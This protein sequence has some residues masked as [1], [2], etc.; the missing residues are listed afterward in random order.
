VLN[1]FSPAYTDLIAELAADATIHA[2]VAVV[3]WGSRPPRDSEGDAA[4]LAGYESTGFKT[5]GVVYQRQPDCSMRHWIR[6]VA[7]TGAAVVLGMHP[8]VLQGWERYVTSYGRETLLVHSLGN[9]VSHGGYE[10]TKPPPAF[11]GRGYDSEISLLLRRTSVL[12]QFGLQWNAARNWAEVS[13]LS[14]VPLYRRLTDIGFVEPTLAAENKTTYEIHVEAVSATEQP[15]EHAFVVDRFGPLRDYA[16]G[17]GVYSG[18]SWEAALDEDSGTYS[19][20][21]YPM[22]NAPVSTVDANLYSEVSH[23][24]NDGSVVPVPSSHCLKCEP[25]NNEEDD[26]S[27]CRWCEYQTYSYC[28][29][30]SNTKVYLGESIPWDECLS[31]AAANA[32]CSQYAYAGGDIGKCTCM[33]NGE[34][35]NLARSTQSQTVY[36]RVCGSSPE[37][38]QS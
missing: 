8:H 24:N 13:C 22:S 12:L 25:V 11:L 32:S 23:T 16:S 1:C 29:G 37:L 17:G 30:P 7:E 20:S 14:Y 19:H 15:V 26:G 27:G 33:R 2:V 36:V 3:H 18:Q 10:E 28:A 34:K 31:M 35:C 4:R 21:C 5:R 38:P 9:F 6:N